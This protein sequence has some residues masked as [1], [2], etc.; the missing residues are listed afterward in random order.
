MIPNRG[1]Y[2]RD[3]FGVQHCRST[4]TENKHEALIIAQEYESAAQGDRLSR[5]ANISR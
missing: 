4:G 2:Y 1:T 5:N 3:A